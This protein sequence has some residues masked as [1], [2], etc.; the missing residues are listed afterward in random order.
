[1]F[2]IIVENLVENAIA[3]S[4]SVD[5]FIAIR[6]TEV[7]NGTGR[8]IMEVED[9]GQGIG[10]QY[11]PLI[12]EMYFRGNDRSKGNGLGLY[13]VKKAVG[14]LS[15]TVAFTSSVGHG[16]VFSI[17]LPTNQHVVEHKAE[18]VVTV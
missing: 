10:E 12:F 6:V 17:D 13:I 14:K 5:P 18:H 8:L 11:Q 7:N 16:S 4:R 3:F 2:K 1:M 15:G 9:N